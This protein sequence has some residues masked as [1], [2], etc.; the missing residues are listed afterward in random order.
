MAQEINQEIN[1]FNS[2]YEIQITPVKI[3]LN[4]EDF[5]FSLW[6]SDKI[7]YIYGKR[8]KTFNSLYEILWLIN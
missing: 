4:P 6:D 8:N 2:L 5:Q 1:S 3:I 7:I